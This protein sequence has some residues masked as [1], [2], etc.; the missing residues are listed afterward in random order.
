MPTALLAQTGQETPLS[1]TLPQCIEKA[2]AWAPQISSAM[3]DKEVVEGKLS[4]AKGACFLPDVH[5][6]VLGGPVP[7]VPNGSGPPTFPKVDTDFT[8]LGP[9]IQARV[10]AIQPIY[11]FGKLKHLRLAAEKGVDAKEA[12]IDSARNEVI[13][14]VKKAYFGVI[15]LRSVQ[16][17]LKE[18]QDR[19]NE[20]K[21]KVESMLKKKSGEVTQIDLMR[22][23]VFFAE[24]AKES[25][26]VQNGI[27]LGTKTLGILVGGL[28]SPPISPADPVLRARDMDLKPLQYYLD[29]SR[30][31]RPEI[32][33][34]DDLVS[35]KKSLMKSVQAD[36]FPTLFL[37][38]FYAYGKAPDR[39][40]IDNP[41]LKDD[42]NF[43]SGGVALGMEQKLSFHMTSG[44]YSEAKAEYLKAQADRS[45]GLMGI[46]LEI[47][48]AYSDV[49]SKRDAMHAA[50]DGFKAG[51]SWVTATTLNFNVGLVPVKDL[52]E[53]FVAY[54]KVKLGYFDVIHDFDFALTD[55]VRAAGEEIVEIKGNDG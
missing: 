6:R 33:Q 39:E 25:I 7:D 27:D 42:F 55:L 2:L 49:I 32:R 10:E 44:R 40:K 30:A 38:G 48:K 46:E 19:A 47:R 9:F 24:T 52:L 21:K 14:N 18:I 20:A 41:F 12:Q 17:F 4:Q 23:D 8:D 5:L 31:N 28:A 35:I 16:E 45:L 26:E 3:S 54:S 34:L 53:A 51:R 1:L 11:T 13:K 50:R 22:L 36:L 15:A 29:S 43:N 37:G